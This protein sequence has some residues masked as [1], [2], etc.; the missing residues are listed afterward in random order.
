MHEE[1]SPDRIKCNMEKI[2]EFYC[3]MNEIMLDLRF[4]RGLSEKKVCI[5]RDLLKEIIAEWKEKEYIPKILCSLFIDF[6][7]SAVASADMYDE[8]TRKEI[9]K[10]ADEMEDLMRICVDTSK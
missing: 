2:S 10:F 7:P 8:P 6:W 1:I 5:L 3:I 9:L 4:L